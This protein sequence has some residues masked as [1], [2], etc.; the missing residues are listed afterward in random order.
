[1]ETT[2]DSTVATTGWINN[3]KTLKVDNLF[4][5]VIWFSGLAFWEW[6]WSDA[7][8]NL[9]DKVNDNCANRTRHRCQIYE[10]L[11][12]RPWISSKNCYR[13]WFVIGAR[14]C[15]WKKIKFQREDERVERQKE[16]PSVCRLS[17]FLVCCCFCPPFSHVQTTFQ[18]CGVRVMYPLV[19]GSRHISSL[20]LVPFEKEQENLGGN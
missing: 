13:T 18:V 8:L 17:I 9:V 15:F 1:M 16:G 19:P 20:L 10:L 12:C 3:D 6:L 7:I 5:P 4:G 11:K 14:V 2:T